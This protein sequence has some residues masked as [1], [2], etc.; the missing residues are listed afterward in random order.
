M[1]QGVREECQMHAIQSVSLKF[2]I[3]LHARPYAS[4]VPC[5]LHVCWIVSPLK[6]VYT[7]WFVRIYVRK[8]ESDPPVRPAKLVTFLRK[9]N[10]HISCPHVHPPNAILGHSLYT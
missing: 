5:V 4:F 7:L 2:V 9:K 8:T 3:S 10:F 6:Y 1:D